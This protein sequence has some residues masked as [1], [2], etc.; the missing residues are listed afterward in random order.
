MA[1]RLRIVLGIMICGIGAVFAAAEDQPPSPRLTI[2]QPLS[3]LKKDGSEIPLQPGT[4]RLEAAQEHQ[5]RLVPG[6]TADPILIEAVELPHDRELTDPLAGTLATDDDTIHVVLFL[7]GGKA[8]EAVGSRSGV[9]TRAGALTSTQLSQ[10]Q[11][12]PSKVNTLA[13]AAKTSLPVERNT[14]AKSSGF[15]PSCLQSS[16]GVECFIQSMTAPPS[17]LTSAYIGGKWAPWT[18]LGGSITS[19]PSCFNPGP[20]FP[21]GMDNIAC[22]ALGLN[23]RLWLLKKADGQSSI[24]WQSIDFGSNIHAP[25]GISCVNYSDYARIV[26]HCYAR[27]K[28]NT[29]DYHPIYRIG[30]SDPTR[31]ESD[32]W[33]PWERVTGVYSIDSKPECLVTYVPRDGNVRDYWNV[34]CYG[35]RSGKLVRIWETFDRSSSSLVPDGSAY[36]PIQP[37]L[38]VFSGQISAPP[39]CTERSGAGPNFVVCAALKTDGSLVFRNATDPGVDRWQSVAGSVLAGPPTCLTGGICFAV[40]QDQKLW[41]FDLGTG[42]TPTRAIRVP[43]SARLLPRLTCVRAGPIHCFAV[44]LSTNDLMHYQIAP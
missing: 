36:P 38:T 25:D 23:S 39:S 16:R 2:D 5:L 28:V 7:P 13:D 17:L 41:R 6:A 4:Y 10:V 8:L 19:G 30:Y 1:I 24:N 42:S 37:T 3:F 12:S 32:G 33:G 15:L 20:G 40:G 35:W 43:G 34:H 18:S 14:G 9:R 21:S 29:G 31:P 26:Y 44:A 11:L 27:N 22:M